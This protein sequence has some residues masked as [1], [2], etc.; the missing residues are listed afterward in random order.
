V[1][2]IGE[3]WEAQVFLSTESDTVA[4]GI[5][6]HNVTI[7]DGVWWG[8]DIVPEPASFTLLAMGVSL[9]FCYD[10]TCRTLGAN[11]AT[12]SDKIEDAVYR[13]MARGNEGR[14]IFHGASLKA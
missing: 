1:G 3:D 6:T 12:D 7:Y 14:A 2:L 10:A 9:S 4:N 13:V 5:T 11:R 8:F